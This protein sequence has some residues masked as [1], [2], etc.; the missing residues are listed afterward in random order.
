[1]QI[2]LDAGDRKLVISAGAILLALLIIVA[3]LSPDEESDSGIPSTYSAKS[4][5]AKAAFL[6]LQDLGYKTERWEQ[7]PE[8]LPVD[9]H[10]TILVLAS[11][12][13]L[14]NAAQKHEIQRYVASGGRILAA[15]Y[16]AAQCLPFDRGRIIVE[17]MAS[18]WKTAQPDLPSPLTR[19]GEIK[20]SPDSYWDADSAVGLTHYSIDGN[21]VVISYKIGKGEVI[22]WGATTPLINSGISQAGNLDLLLNSLGSP[23]NTRVLW[24]EYFHG[25]SRSLAAYLG[26][27]PVGFGLV[28]CGFIFLAFIFTFSRRNVPIRPLIEPPRLSPLEFV[29]TLG[30]LYRRAEVNSMAVEVAYK[31]LRHLLATRLGLNADVA[32]T[33]LARAARERLNYKDARFEELLTQAENAVHDY[34]LTEAAA[35]ELVQELTEHAEKLRL[36]SREQEKH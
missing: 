36:I 2:A 27:P 8:D 15:G 26:D 14:P 7:P 21:A 11:P 12:T 3:V 28:Q 25:S 1:M 9:P 35:L 5:G 33:T 17:R 22:W 19:G 32:T 10:G 13:R 16:S 6:L 29:Q 24:D 18:E 4:N 34:D 31:R 30:G 20:V 23:Q